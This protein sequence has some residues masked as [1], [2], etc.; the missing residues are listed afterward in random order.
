MNFGVLLFHFLDP[1]LDRVDPSSMS[2]QMIM[3]LLVENITNREY[4]T[5]DP[6]EDLEQWTGVTLDDGGNVRHIDWAYEHRLEG[7][8][9]L[10]WLPHTL[11]SIDVTE[12]RLCGSLDLDVLPDPLV[13]V[14]LDS[15]KFE[16][17]VSL[18]HLPEGLQELNLGRNPLSGPID[19]TSLPAGL[20]KLSLY[21]TAIEGETDFS[22]LPD[23]LTHL[24]VE[25][26]N[27]SGSIPFREGL[28]VAVI[29]SQVK[30]L[31]A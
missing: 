11:Q 18:C 31:E 8:F 7:P 2:Q 21:S 12:N 16:G 9:P 26:T 5:G 25:N 6:P 24:Y 4:Y 29:L 19:L 27:L 15:N 3:E 14:I 22:K 13:R 10:Q 23:G 28:M 1:S 17:T 30:M 20:R